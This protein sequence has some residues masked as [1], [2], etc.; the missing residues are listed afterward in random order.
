MFNKEKT[1]SQ[2][3]FNSLYAG[4]NSLMVAEELTG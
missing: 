3:A 1:F 4:V 2:M